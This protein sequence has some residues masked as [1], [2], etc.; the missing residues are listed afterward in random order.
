MSDAAR[1]AGYAA[2]WAAG[3]RAAATL[4]EAQRVREQ[5]EHERREAM[6][7]EQVRSAANALHAAV[8]QW[9]ALAAPVLAEA[10]A[11]LHGAAI[12]LAEAVVAR[13]VRPGPDGVESLLARALALP[14]G[15]HATALRLSAHDMPYVESARERGTISVPD[16]MTISVDAGLGPGESITEHPAGMLDARIGQALARARAA[17]QDE[18]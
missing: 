10:E 7:D 2:G 18:E 6:R 8:A 3:A 4:A 9:Q 16:G 15:A 13:E 14:S 5:E 11:T 12:D 17:L 1:T